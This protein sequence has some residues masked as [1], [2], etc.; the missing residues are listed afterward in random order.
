MS[1]YLDDGAHFS[2][3]HSPYKVTSGASLQSDDVATEVPEPVRKNAGADESLES[4]VA[5]SHALI[6]SSLRPSFP[7]FLND[8]SGSFH[9][10]KPGNKIPMKHFLSK[11]DTHYTIRIN[12]K[13]MIMMKFRII[14]RIIYCLNDSVLK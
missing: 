6:A 11:I 5:D 3:E 4:H 1:L 12:I 9:P 2:A 14:T 8:H 13:Q 10:Q 7:I